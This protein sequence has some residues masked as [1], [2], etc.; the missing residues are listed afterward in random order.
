MRLALGGDGLRG[1][2]RARQEKARGRRNGERADAWLHHT[3]LG[4]DRTGHHRI[5]GTL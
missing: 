3:Y 4:E 2:G 5:Q 1:D